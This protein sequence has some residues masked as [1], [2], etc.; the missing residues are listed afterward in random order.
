MTTIYAIL[1][2]G[3]FLSLGLAFAVWQLIRKAKKAEVL[4]RENE[5]LMEE[6]KAQKRI[7]DIFTKPRGDKHTVI[8]G[9]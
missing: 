7:T 9:L 2:G 5:K 8:D 3:G 4:E 6:L 1:A